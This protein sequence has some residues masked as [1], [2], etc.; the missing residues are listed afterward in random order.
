MQKIL[1]IE[2]NAAIRENISEILEMANYKVLVAADGKTGVSIAFAQIPDLVLCDIMLPILDGYGV[3]HMLQKNSELKTTPFIFLTAKS[4]HWEV[5][6]GMEIGADDYITKPFDGTE[7][8]TAIESRLKKA[9]L[10]RGEFDDT[11]HGINK[12]ITATS[13]E[14]ALEMLK[15]GR[16]TLSY[17]NKQTIYSEGSNPSQLFY[18]VKGKAKTFKRNQDGK[19]LVVDLYSEGDFLGYTAL[20]EGVKYCETAETLEETILTEIPKSEFEH[21]M[22]SSLVVMK[23]FIGILARNISEK[24]A[25]LLSIAYNSLRKKVADALV[26]LYNKYN[27]AHKEHFSIDL[28]RE[29][30]AAVAG[31]ATESLI[32]TLSDFKNESLISLEGRK[33]SILNYGKLERMFN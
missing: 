16:N 33:I 10:M 12:L 13:N 23:K 21:L 29:N 24:E 11:I 22:N 31:V 7:L 27:P 6:K 4:E 20:L 17:K 30:L 3:L 15:Q 9:R 19:E 25:Q 5:R 28:T 18:I 8:L 14:N 32:R 2:D 1:V 26:I